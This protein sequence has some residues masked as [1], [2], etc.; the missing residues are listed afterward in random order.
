MATKLLEVELTDKEELVVRLRPGMARLVPQEAAQHARGAVKE[1]LMAMRTLLDVTI[2]KMDAQE[3]P[4]VKGK[5][6]IKV[7]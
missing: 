6:K 2:K 1:T 4:G 3:K 7:Q 5:T